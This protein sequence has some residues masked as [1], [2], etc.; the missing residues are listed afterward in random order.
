MAGRPRYTEAELRQYFARVC[1]PSSSWDSLLSVRGVPAS[2]QLARLTQL[3]KHQLLKVPFENL[4][5]HYSWHRTVDV[6]PRHLFRKIVG[7]PQSHVEEEDGEAKA[8]KRFWGSGGAGRGGYCME[9]NTFFHTVLLSTGYDV[10]MSGARVY[11]RATASYGGFSHCVNIVTLADGARYMLD[12]GFGGNGPIAPIP[13]PSLDPSS[14]AVR[15]DKPPEHPHIHPAAVRLR[16]EPIPQQTNQRCRV[17]ILE[18]RAH[19]G[20]DEAE[21]WI[22][23]YCFVDQEFLLEDIRGLNLNPWRSPHSFFT[24]KILMTRFTTEREAEGEGE[25]PGSPGED[26]IDGAE[27]DGAITLFEDTLK[28]RRKGELRVEL[29]FENEEQRLDALRRYFDIEFDD[30]DRDAI[31]GTVAEITDAW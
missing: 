4:T 5:Q 2:E 11:A 7:Q 28:W 25:G 18:H 24:R 19:A 12:V 27:I 31:R 16:H 3:M 30:E 9:V 14:G 21:A 15:G 17:W 26:A 22:P 29:K 6:S 13:L 1:V 23:N 20:G 8:G 10:H